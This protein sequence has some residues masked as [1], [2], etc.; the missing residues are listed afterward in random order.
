M[1]TIIPP[2]KNRRRPQMSEARP[3]GM[4]PTA[5]TIMCA[6]RI[7]PTPVAEAPWVTA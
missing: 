4:E 5:A 6:P 1:L 2:I 7:N 3:N